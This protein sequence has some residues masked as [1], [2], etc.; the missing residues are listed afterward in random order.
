[1]ANGNL[2]FKTVKGSVRGG[3]EGLMFYGEWKNGHPVFY[4]KTK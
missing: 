4:E 1:M 3:V 2:A